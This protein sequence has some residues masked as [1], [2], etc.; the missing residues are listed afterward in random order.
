[1]DGALQG[2]PLAA[3]ITSFRGKEAVY[4]Y[5]ASSDEHRNRCPPMPCM[6]AL[7]AARDVGCEFYDFYGIPPK[8]DPATRWPVCIA[9]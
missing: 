9:S 8:E 6:A 7:R 3:I 2:D 5:G 1:M 4:L